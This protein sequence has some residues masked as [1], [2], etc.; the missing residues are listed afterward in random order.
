MSTII[1]GAEY[2]YVQADTLSNYVYIS[3]IPNEHIHQI[4]VLF[5]LP[6]HFMAR[7]FVTILT[8]ATFPILSYI[9]IV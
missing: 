4:Q 8:T 3:Q 9:Y 5:W 7:T 6:C 1:E 2:A